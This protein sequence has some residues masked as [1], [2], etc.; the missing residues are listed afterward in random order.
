MPLFSLFVLALWVL[1]MSLYQFGKFT[2]LHFIAWVGIVFVI[3]VIVE[4]VVLAR[5]AQPVWPWRRR[6]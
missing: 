6:A 2:D 1:L 5:S 3:T 4:C